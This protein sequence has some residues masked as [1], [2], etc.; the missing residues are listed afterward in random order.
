M[1]AIILLCSALA[2]SNCVGLAAVPP[3]VSYLGT[4][5]TVFS[6]LATGKGT[7]DHVIS[8]I[9]EKDCAL[10]PAGGWH[11][12][13]AESAEAGNGRRTGG[14][15]G[16]IAPRHRLRPA[17]GIGGGRAAAAISSSSFY[18][19]CRDRHDRQMRRRSWRRRP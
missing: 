19:D 6:Y 10:H 15:S 17:A 5:A 3:T 16:G 7:S 2:L 18:H 9:A 1:R 13:P 14:V 11:L 8:A 12:F 4:A